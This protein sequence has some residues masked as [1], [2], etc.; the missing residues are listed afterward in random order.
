MGCDQ[1]MEGFYRL[2]IHLFVNLM[3][4]V[5]GKFMKLVVVFVVSQQ[6][7]VS[8]CKALQSAFGYKRHVPTKRFHSYSQKSLVRVHVYSSLHMSQKMIFHPVL[9][10]GLGSTGIPKRFVKF[11]PSWSGESSV[12][13][14]HRS[15]VLRTAGRPDGS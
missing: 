12:D 1:N 8:F 13:W 4:I 5:L 3:R 7:K 15:G 10:C 9:F 14:G 6:V 11:P 2:Y